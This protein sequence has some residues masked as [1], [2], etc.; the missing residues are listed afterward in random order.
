MRTSL[1]K[2]RSSP[3]ESVGMRLEN[4]SVMVCICVIQVCA[5]SNRSMKKIHFTMAAEPSKDSSLT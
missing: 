2:C 4:I 1:D 5:D 3:V